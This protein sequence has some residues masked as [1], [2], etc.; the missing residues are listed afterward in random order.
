[1][2][3]ATVPFTHA[4]SQWFFQFAVSDRIVLRMRQYIGMD[5]F[6]QGMTALCVTFLLIFFVMIHLTL[7]SAL[8]PVREASTAAQK[9]TP[10]SLDARL[11]TAQQPKELRP[12]VESFNQGL[13]RLQAGFKRQQEFLSNAA[14]ELKTPLALIRSQIEIT[15]DIPL[16]EKLLADVDRV[17]RQVQ[18][19]L[20]LAETSERQNYQ[21]VHI[22]PRN[23]AREALA[24]LERIATQYGVTLSLKTNPSVIYWQAD[25]GA[26]FTLFKNLLENAIQHSPQDA[27]VRLHIDEDGFSVCDEGP[28]IAQEDLPHIFERFWRGEARK[29]KGAGLGLAICSEIV[30]AHGWKLTVRRNQTGLEMR[31]ATSK[32]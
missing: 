14:H 3:G 24:F 16:R 23:A 30:T 13:N 15:R 1:M 12:L 31:C 26:L 21:M 27:V 22:D 8:Q 17:A 4:G 19:L 18:Q 7:R 20:L 25:H 9:I 6:R 29:E 32:G 2:H 28:G 5:V 10:Q 11:P